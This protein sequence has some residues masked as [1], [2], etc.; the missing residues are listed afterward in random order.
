MG[1][2]RQT[3]DD[4]VAFAADVEPRLRY[5]LVAAHGYDR[6]REATQDALVYAWEHWDKISA[7]SNPA[8][9]LYRIANRRAARGRRH[10]PLLIDL[11][12]TDPPPPEPGL[13]G[14]LRALSRKQRATVLLVE[15]L[16]LTHQEAS[17]ILGVSRSTVQTH[18]ERGLSRLRAALGVSTDA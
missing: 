1:V 4:F 17:E 3:N 16:G 2:E 9:Y 5:A 12:Y 14:A 15:A 13:E 11:P 8:G 18:L 7:A 6:G 10:M